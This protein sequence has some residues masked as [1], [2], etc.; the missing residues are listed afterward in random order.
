MLKALKVGTVVSIIS[1]VE[2]LSG[3]VVPV[4]AG[5]Y[6]SEFVPK[7][8]AYV[9]ITTAGEFQ[10]KMYPFQNSQLEIISEPS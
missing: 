1:A 2:S 10:G 4:P 7:G 9:L 3:L 8:L 5:Q 6:K